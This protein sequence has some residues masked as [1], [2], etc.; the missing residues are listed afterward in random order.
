[1][2]EQAAAGKSATIQGSNQERPTRQRRR[3]TPGEK[4]R[5]VAQ[6]QHS[7]LSRLAFC[8]KHSLCY[9]T[10]RLWVQEVAQEGGDRF[11]EVKLSADGI[12]KPEAERFALAELTAPNGWRVRLPVGFDRLE[13]AALLEVMREC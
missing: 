5:L 11:V 4:R 6:W 10:F 2:P 3:W 13:I 1:M 7:G 8:R 12:A 9:H